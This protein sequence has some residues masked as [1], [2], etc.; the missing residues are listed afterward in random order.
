MEDYFYTIEVATNPFWM[1]RREGW[2]GESIELVI[3]DDDPDGIGSVESETCGL[4][5]VH[6]VDGSTTAYPVGS[7]VTLVNT[8]DLLDSDSP[9]WVPFDGTADYYSLML[10][11]FTMEAGSEH[12]VL[13]ERPEEFSYT[14]NRDETFLYESTP[15]AAG[16]IFTPAYSRPRPGTELKPVS[17]I[18]EAQGKADF[19]ASLALAAYRLAGD[20]VQADRINDW[21]VAGYNAYTN[22]AEQIRLLD[23]TDLCMEP[24]TFGGSIPP[25]GPDYPFDR[26][27]LKDGIFTSG[28]AA[29]LVGRSADA[30][31]LAFRGTNDAATVEANWWD[32]LSGTTPD[33]ADWDN[34]S[35]H[36]AHYEHLLERLIAYAD[37]PDN[38]IEKVF[39]TGHSLGAAMAE[40]LTDA[41]T[42]SKV[43][44]MTF[45]SPGYGFDDDGAEDRQSNIW[46]DGDPIL[47]ATAFADN[48]GDENVI[49][50][51]MT[52]ATGLSDTANLHSMTLYR[53]MMQFFE[54]AGWADRVF[55][56]KVHGVDY[57]SFF[58]H[59]DM[60][61]THD[62]FDIWTIGTAADR[63]AGSMDSDFIL[64]GRNADKVLARAGRDHVEGG[65]GADILKGQA[66]FD[67]LL[68]EGGRD[69][70]IGGRGNDRL[71]GGN[72]KDILYGGEKTD[73]LI[74]GLKAD[75]FVFR[76]TSDSPSF[77]KADRIVDFNSTQGDRIILKAIDAKADAPG[78]DAFTFIGRDGYSDTSGELRY[79]LRPAKD[80][81]VILGDT[82]GDGRSDLVIAMDGLQLL[83]AS[84]FIL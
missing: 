49:Y 84:D 16:E 31:F 17:E 60:A 23:G 22:V 27:G 55:T 71:A 57:D 69:R 2:N 68:G 1:T 29:A 42:S 43:E 7:P 76:D 4:P 19:M 65:H 83:H 41:W 56:G 5:V 14:F 15:H 72:G 62:A 20:E 21:S 12:L 78:N 82:D 79:V 66:G 73:T 81:T 47:A 35:D 36:Y 77:R 61:A 51:N 18:F 54:D 10:W 11:H 38:G 37:D 3:R 59:A 40:K 50:H 63:I 6:S 70:L 33:I 52:P 24:G 64:A 53:A 48:E 74:G 13:N 80:K 75:R 46:I 67:V 32:A 25:V 39:V 45:A 9:W 30:L 44:T 34:K 58:V 26:N 8:Y 28:N